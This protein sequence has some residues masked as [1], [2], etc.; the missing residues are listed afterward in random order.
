MDRK[1]VMEMFNRK[2]RIGALATSSKNGEVNVA[3][4][5]SPQMI[6]ENTIIMA[7][8]RRPH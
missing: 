1:S 5:G 2:S 6:D 4:F 7:I 3:V 8:R